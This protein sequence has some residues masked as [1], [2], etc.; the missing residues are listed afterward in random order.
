VKLYYFPVAPNPTKVRIYLAEK[1]LE[2]EQVRVNL[3]EGEQKS[4]EHLARNPFGKLPVLE[5][6]DGT[7]LTESLAIIELFE[8]LHPDPPMLGSTPLERARVRMLERVADLGV[9]IP[10]ARIIHATRSP[11]GLPPV[12]EI[13]AAERSQLPKALEVLDAKLEDR[14]FLAGERPTLADCTLAAAFG[15]ARFGQVEIDSGFAHLAR[16]SAE[17]EARPSVR[18]L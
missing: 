11:L 13:A 17:F 18:N 4:P 8:E 15:F 12:P 10:V 5:L 7:Y 1:G 2:V 6:D 16:W 14:P 9:L 3:V